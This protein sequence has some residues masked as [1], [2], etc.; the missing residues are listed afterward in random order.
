MRADLASVLITYRR[1]DYL[2]DC[3]PVWN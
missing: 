3:V 2:P 1:P